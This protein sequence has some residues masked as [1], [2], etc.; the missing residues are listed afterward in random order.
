MSQDE[1]EVTTGTMKDVNIYRNFT[2][3][4]IFI[5]EPYVFWDRNLMDQI[6]YHLSFTISY[7]FQE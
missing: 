1:N 6:L 5:S 7:I 4:Q 2:G 3:Q